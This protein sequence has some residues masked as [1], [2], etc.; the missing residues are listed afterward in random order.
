MFVKRLQISFT[1]LES[2]E[3]LGW[4]NGNGRNSINLGKTNLQIYHRDVGGDLDL[5]K[6]YKFIIP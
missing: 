1:L 3:Y 5:M 6:R 4:R 2:I